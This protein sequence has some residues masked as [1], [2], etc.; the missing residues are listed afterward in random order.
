GSESD[1]HW[2][3]WVAYNNKQLLA[4]K[5]RDFE[6]FRARL[7]EW[8]RAHNSH[9]AAFLAGEDLQAFHEADTAFVDYAITRRWSAGGPQ[10]TP[11]YR[12]RPRFIWYGQGVW[13]LHT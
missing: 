11:L 8:L 13:Y 7:K 6:E 2:R 1:D 4:L 12:D 10:G 5:T 9:L 3:H